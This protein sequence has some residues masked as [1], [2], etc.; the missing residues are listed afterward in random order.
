M[1]VLLASIIIFSCMPGVA[2]AET[3]DYGVS[4]EGSEATIISYAGEGG[5]IEIPDVI[6]GK[7]ITKIGESAFRAVQSLT[8]VV[9]PE[10][11][12][13]IDN[14]AF[15]ECTNLKKVYFNGD[16]PVF[17][18]D[19]FSNA[20]PDI[21]VYYPV[22]KSQ[23]WSGFSLYPAQAFCV[24][25]LD[26][27][28]DSKTVVGYQDV[29]NGTIEQPSTPDRTAYTFS[30]WYLEPECQTVWKN[31]NISGNMTLYAKWEPKDVAV[32]FDPLNGSAVQPKTAKYGENITEPEEP[33]KDGYTFGGWFKEKD[34]VNQWN[35]DTD[36]VSSDITLF[37]KW[38]P[39]ICTITFDSM[40]G[41]AVEPVKIKP[42]EKIIKPTDPEK[43]HSLFGGW[44]REKNY[45]D[46]WVFETDTVTADITLYAKW[47]LPMR[48]M[49]GEPDK[50]FSGSGTPEDPFG[51]STPAQL[52][53]VRDY[54]SASFI[55]LNDIDL[56][57]ETS[58]NGAY[59]NNG[60]GWSPIGT[61]A[62]PFTGTFNGDK[63]KII[64]LKLNIHGTSDVYAGLF[65]YLGGTVK[66]LGMEGSLLKADASSYKKVYIGGIA[67]YANNAVIQCCYNTGA[68]QS[69]GINDNYAAG[70]A[71]YTSGGSTSDCLNTGAISSLSSDASS[72]YAGGLAGYVS[73]TALNRCFNIGMVS[74]SAYG[75]AWA[76]GLAGY[77]SG[78]ITNCY[79]IDSVLRSIG[80]VRDSS[81]ARTD[82]QLRE[83]NTYPGFDFDTVWTISGSGSY[84]YAQLKG[85]PIAAP[86]EN[87]SDF[88][89]GRGTCY[90]PYHIET[91]AQLDHIRS[92]PGAFY[93]LQNDLD[94]TGFIGSGSWNPI[95]SQQD[96]FTGHFNGKGHKLVGLT[97]KTENT[98]ANA[99]AGLFG[100]LSGTVANL[101]VENGSIFATAP[102]YAYAG[103]I[104]GYTAGGVILNC[105]N[106]A[107]INSGNV[108]R[109]SYSGGITGFVSNA[110]IQKCTNTG[111]IDSYNGYAGGIAGGGKRCTIDQCQNAGSV[112]GTSKTGYDSY[113][114][115]VAGSISDY[116]TMSNSYST[117]TIQSDIAGGI[118]NNCDNSK[119]E[120]CYNIG[121]IAGA[122]TAK[123]IST[124][125][126]YATF[127]NCFYTD[128]LLQSGYIGSASSNPS[129]Q[130]K[131]DAD[132]RKQETFTGFDFDNVWTMGGNENYPYPELRNTEA[133]IPPVNTSDF[134]GGNGTYYNPY[135]IE[136]P[137]QLDNIRNF[138]GSCFSLQNDIDLTQ[139][140]TGKSNQS[141]EPIGGDTRFI[142]GFLGNGHIITGLK[143][144][145]SAAGKAGLFGY[146]YGFIIQLGMEKIDITVNRNTASAG[147]F[148][149]CINGSVYQ[150][151]STGS[152]K[153]TAPDTAYG[154]GIAG[155]AY[156]S[157]IIE[158]CN[159][160]GIDTKTSRYDNTGGIV[161]S[162]NG[163]MVKNCMNIGTVSGLKNVGGI[164]GN[165]TS[166]KNALECCFNAGI[167]HGTR[168]AGGISGS[169]NMKNCYYF[170]NIPRLY[171]WS[172]NMSYARTDEALRLQ[173]TYAG[174][175]FDSIWTLREGS[176]YPYAQL[177]N[178]DMPVSVEN[179]PIFVRGNGTAFAPYVI[180]DAQQLNKMREYPEACFEL[181]SDIDLNAAVWEPV[182]TAAAPFTGY[183][184]GKGHQIK[185]LRVAVNGGTTVYAGLF[186]CL[187]GTAK[188]LY[189]V[190]AAVT[191]AGD[192]AYAG[193]LCGYTENGYVKN[194]IVAGS[195]ALNGA[196]NYGGGFAGYEQTGDIVCCWNQ[197][198]I[199][200]GSGTYSYL[201]GIAGYQKNLS[202]ISNCI[203]TGS[204]A[205]TNMANSHNTGGI[206]GYID[207][208]YITACYNTG[209]ITVGDGAQ[210]FAG[211]VIGNKSSGTAQ[212]C[213]YLDNSA[214]GIGN[215]ADSGTVKKTDAEMK[216]KSTFTGF[217]FSNI[218]TIGY[219]PL[220]AYPKLI[221][222]ED[223]FIQNI[224]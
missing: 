17:G 56:S 204:V 156:N 84:P 197:S 6:E 22:S 224:F 40:G 55:L 173:S 86:G 139:Y 44:Y 191:A 51:I 157:Q 49:A 60:A 52:N 131:T 208:G 87:T 176:G 133:K 94:L 4:I 145:L 129:I 30:G 198:N 202:Y 220:Y 179:N 5:D 186:G 48:A 90:D 119:V 141:F 140:I 104:A 108:V 162:A 37:A 130:A 95:G 217:D 43:S 203:N 121:L 221:S 115:G 120:N 113:A 101:A 67:G 201:G 31:E 91:A 195:V 68:V 114:A 172:T 216:Q 118:L 111:K 135:K 34:C 97:V 93:M 153:I 36:T 122:N 209:S 13:S 28:Y 33:I 147:A 100:Y 105:L 177:K 41:S 123:P 199:Q 206:L 223:T 69:V 212:N 53:A 219:D 72:S 26:M 65:G 24:V 25:T 63:H 169:A 149:G 11:I 154:G 137:I 39:V 1:A 107:S 10:G 2:S 222:L 171:G 211:A 58:E 50:P 178:V 166:S 180:A 42:G 8:M 159:A 124:Y 205:D 213:Y 78:T 134:A 214:K 16:L 27:Q 110:S 164:A 75:T 7:T 66:N 76:G 200:C 71:G 64:G 155:L 47:E 12:N 61:A 192:T 54:L 165:S 38:S 185:D 215:A 150:C 188:N 19:V 3:D 132:F 210:N 126:Y 161:G 70:I 187:N 96:P 116:S 184:D 138:E 92:F 46:P 89:G 144:T 196:K 98:E 45:N 15:S 146:Y 189:I 193:I 160:T 167:I 117:G 62:T 168:A 174:F 18:A 80:S 207:S 102:N 190:D 112:T 59:Y 181:A 106:N 85:M 57:A 142:G 183:L 109:N 32:T 136:T 21:N 194:F 73:G 14:L 127:A 77:T 29:N 163:S 125:Q 218:W 148:A 83:Q 9:L 152:I 158:C 182:G 175:D 79:H 88:T 35:F 170:D 82:A 128:A 23:S 143:Q 151:Y 99:Y 103:A 74:A 81:Y 20:A